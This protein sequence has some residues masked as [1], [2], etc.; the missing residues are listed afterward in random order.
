MVRRK[1][2]K[3][4][5]SWPFFLILL[6]SVLILGCLII[7]SSLVRPFC[8]SS[9]NCKESMKLD[10]ENGV[11]GVFNGQVVVPPKVD[12]AQK[13][14]SSKV[15]AEATGTGEKHVYVDLGSQTL[16]AYQGEDLYMTAAVSTGKWNKT[17]VGEF[18]IWGMFRATKMSGGS[19]ADYYYLPNV[20]YVMFFSGSGVPAGSGFSLHGAYWHNNFGH[21]MSH[22]CVNMRTVDA[23]KLYEW[24]GDNNPETKI[25]IY[26]QAPI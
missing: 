1:V 9:G 7:F 3:S 10:I 11:T 24:V 2:Q 16:N 26:G 5:F 17:P 23:Q 20:P 13:K 22:G 6:A 15:L 12:L 14:T 25:T 21:P 4:S 8:A 19:G 18:T